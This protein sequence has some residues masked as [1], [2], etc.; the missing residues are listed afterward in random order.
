VKK[1]MMAD[2]ALLPGNVCHLWCSVL[3]PNM[4]NASSPLS[5]FNITAGAVFGAISPSGL[6]G[7]T[8]CYIVSPAAAVGNIVR[9]L[10]FTWPSPQLFYTRSQ[11]FQMY[12]HAIPR[13]LDLQRLLLLE[14]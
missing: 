14:S 3:S 10:S 4:T 7:S 2:H 11:S 13:V 6:A 1:N 12:Y 8:A 9:R 5:E